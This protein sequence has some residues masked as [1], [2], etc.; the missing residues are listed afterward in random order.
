LMVKDL[1]LAMAVAEQSG[2][3]NPMGQL[4]QTLY[5]SLQS[6][7]AGQEDFSSIMRQVQKT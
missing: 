4:A 6:E 5:Q 2:V 1:G 7:G 3:S